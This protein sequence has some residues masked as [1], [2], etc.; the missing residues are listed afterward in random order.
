[1]LSLGHTSTQDQAGHC[2]E[3]ARENL[4]STKI[5]ASKSCNNGRQ[6]L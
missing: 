6:T 4:A 3:L 1:M 2:T 5:A